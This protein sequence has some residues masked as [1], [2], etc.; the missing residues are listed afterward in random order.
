[1]GLKSMV[2]KAAGK[3]ADTT[4]KLAS[5][6]PKQ[7]I[8]TQLKHDT[9]LSEM[10]D[11]NDAAAVELTNRLLAAGSIE[12]FNSYLPQISRLYL[13]VDKD[14]EYG[15]KFDADHNV[16]YVNI[17]RWVTDKNENS[18]EKLINVYAVLSNEKCNIAL[19]F[20][21]KMTRTDVYIGVVNTDDNPNSDN[22][23]TLMKRL[24]DALAG[25]FPGSKLR[26][27][28]SEGSLAFIDE[29]K[30]YSV[31]SMSNVP[32]ESS[33][34]FISQTIEKLLDGTVPENTEKEYTVILLATPIQDVEERKLKLS[35]LYS[36]LHPY[37][38]WETGF[39][40]SE[41]GAQA[42]TATFG[43]NVGASAGIQNGQT[44]VVSQTDTNTSG[45]SNTSTD[46]DSYEV[47]QSESNNIT[48]ISAH[49][50]GSNSSQTDNYT[51]TKKENDKLF[52]SVKAGTSVSVGDT[53]L[54]KVGGELSST[55]EN[56]TSSSTTTTNSSSSMEAKSIS[57]TI[58]KAIQVGKS[59]TNAEGKA[60]SFAKTV[61][62]SI[63]KAV[64]VAEGISKGTNF[65]ANAGANFARSSTITALVGKNESINQH[66]VNYNIIHT[67]QVLETQMKRF[68]ACTALGMWDFAGYVLS[69]DVDVANNVAHS[70]LA[71][72]QGE[73]SYTS[74]SAVNLWRNNVADVTKCRIADEICGY[75][76]DLR[77]PIFGLNPEAIRENYSFSVYPP[78]VTPTTPLSGKELAYSLNFPQKS[79]TGLP[80]IECSAFGRN[81]FINDEIQKRDDGISIG[82][83]YH[84]YHE[85]KNVKVQISQ[86][87]LAAHTFITGST[88]SGKSNAVYQILYNALNN[89][90][91]F[92]V[93][94]PAK[95][96]Y[97]DIFGNDRGV[98]VYS[99]NSKKAPLL[100]INPFSFPE[101]IHILEHLDR[102]VEIFNVCWPMY[103]AMPAVLKS[104][105][106]RA[107]EDCG[108]DL[109]ES[110]NP[111]G[112]NLYPTFADVS[113]N[114]KSIID[115]SEYDD[116]NKGAYKGSLLTRLNSL[117]NGINGLIFSANEISD[118]DLFDKNVIV[119]ISRVGS[120][121]TRSLIMGMLILK[122]QEY[123][124]S[125]KDGSNRSLKHLTV[126]EEAHNILKKT[127]GVSSESV[128]LAGKSVE[129]ISNAISEMRTYGEGF[130]IADQSPGLLDMSAI[131]NTN[132]KIILHLPDQTDRE[133]VGRAASLNDDQIAELAKLP[134]GVAAVYQNEWIQPVLCKFHK[135]SYDTGKY[136]YSPE[137]DKNPVPDTNDRLFIAEL[138]SKGASESDVDIIQLK[139][140]MD[141]INLPASTRISILKLIYSPVKEPGIKKLAPIMSALF[142]EVKESVKEAYAETQDTN[143]LT[144]AAHT[145]LRDN[146][147]ITNGETERII[148]QSIINQH[149][150]NDAYIRNGRMIVK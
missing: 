62:N 102:L 13:P 29:D 105:M 107:Y 9:Y 32:T 149:I 21:R 97:K 150:L 128:N 25:N 89:G 131:R 44:Q 17:T 127:S 83:I 22:V 30:P 75:L 93:I 11:P 33:E 12:I 146:N 4:A 80:V 85:E 121:E 78:L 56:T 35:K 68:D 71:L 135:Y 133:L 23:N 72:T 54:G 137:T 64:G 144:E 7:L 73:Q 51:V 94:E 119:D 141:A 118:V 134:R 16:K 111:Y 88:G 82:N 37:A 61:S 100:R 99:T 122:L 41:S 40:F 106:E 104:A 92:L 38:Q 31:A 136:V 6:S 113:R 15:E 47:S 116:E 60:K 109:V 79:V 114:V 36:G 126:L 117:T 95:G 139:D 5:L 77:H 147:I 125:T 108:W 142:P 87:S 59:I 115:S 24:R 112:K 103:A 110:D 1:M 90:T 48:D 70:Y 26:S 76:R 43:V 53:E 138:I 52:T 81:V 3:A 148:I 143:E 123:R 39:Q 74:H 145:I 86:K 2:V 69:E 49:N 130:I 91:K 18:L 63:S 27:K 120:S 66:F 10:P 129:M 84:M 14:V 46:S 50:E 45:D 96:E 34:K 8:D 20:N 132:T 57:D 42:S 101:D 98:S 55:I 67:L 28:N 124:M 58:G 140:K 65:G 19:I